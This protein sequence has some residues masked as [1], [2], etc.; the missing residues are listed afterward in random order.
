[1]SR[2]SL[3]VVACCIVGLGGVGCTTPSS[4]EP[5]AR[6]VA[7]TPPPKAAAGNASAGGAHGP[8]IAVL[9]T[10]DRRVELH[11]GT[12]VT[13]RNNEGDLV[14]DD[15]TLDELAERDPFLYEVCRASFAQNGTEYVDARLDTN[16]AAPKLL[17]IVG[18]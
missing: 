3:C 13:V 14:A 4:P 1:M 12:R 15:V 16:H 5:A 6:A 10:R 7:T 17:G 11:S 18:D 8:T 9:Q 2:L